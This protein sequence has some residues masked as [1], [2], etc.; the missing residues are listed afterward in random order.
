MVDDMPTHS[1]IT[2]PLLVESSPVVLPSHTDS[3][4][5]AATSG[6]G[7]AYSL[8]SRLPQSQSIV[9]ATPK[10]DVVTVPTQHQRELILGLVVLGG[11][12]CLGSTIVLLMFVALSVYRYKPSLI[13]SYIHNVMI[14]QCCN[15][16][17]SFSC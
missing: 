10:G 14:V 3:S 13:K 4:T 5:H 2:T 12:L 9:S 16:M 11:V 7:V 6:A 8:G 1:S 15:N 17:M